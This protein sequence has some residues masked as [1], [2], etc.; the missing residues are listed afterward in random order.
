M[1]KFSLYSKKVYLKQAFGQGKE[2]QEKVVPLS[3]IFS[4]RLDNLI[5]NSDNKNII[6][7]HQKKILQALDCQ[8]QRG[9]IL[10]ITLK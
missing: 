9:I 8:L 7:P 1:K 3:N 2:L 6:N 4:T 5:N 10:L